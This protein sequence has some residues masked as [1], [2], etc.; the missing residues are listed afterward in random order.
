MKCLI[1]GEPALGVKS[2]GDYQERACPKC[3][4][5]RIST[6]ALK[7]MKAHGWRF[8]VELARRWLAQQQGSEAIP[9]ID[10]NQA[11]RLIDV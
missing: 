3:G 10:S 8:D 11:G 6:P 1:C 7:L 9:T 2:E 5:Y 4:R